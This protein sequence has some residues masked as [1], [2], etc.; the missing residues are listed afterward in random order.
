MKKLN[1]LYKASFLVILAAFFFTA[2]ELDPDLTDDATVSFVEEAG[3]VSADAIIDGTSDFQVRLSATQ[4]TN[5]MNIL[6]LLRDGTELDPSEFSIAGITVSNNPQLLTDGDRASFTFDIT[7]TPHVSGTATYDF[8]VTSDIDGGTAI[9]T[10]DITVEDEDPTLTINGPNNSSLENPGF[11]SINL[12]GTP[13]SS[14]LV[15][16][17][18]LQDG[19]LITELD[20]LACNDLSTP[21]TANPNLLDA[22]DIDGFDKMF[23]I[24]STGVIG[25]QNYTIVITDE[26]SNEASVDYVIE[27]E[28]LAT[29]LTNQFQGVLLYNNAGP[30]FGA[31]DLDSG[32]SVSSGDASADIVDLGFNGGS[33]WAKSISP[34]GSTDLRSITNGA[35]FDSVTSRELLIEAFDAG[36]S[37]AQTGELT[38]GISYTARINEDYYIL[39]VVDIVETSGDNLDFYRFDIKQSLN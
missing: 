24:Q 15:S 3:F 10:L 26:A 34:A 14:P 18:V 5:E 23:F 31:I 39:T 16:I 22:A 27:L 11:V 2:C 33:D 29:P 30:E 35:T 32:T 19:A 1:L 25:T 12:V 9:S 36:T 20:R 13:G 28:E 8:V 4:G 37:L 17:S 21:F 38:V 6:T 7:I